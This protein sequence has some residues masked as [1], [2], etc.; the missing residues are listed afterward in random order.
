MERLEQL[1]DEA[2]TGVQVGGEVDGQVFHT[3]EDVA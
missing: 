1:S 3:Y 2:V